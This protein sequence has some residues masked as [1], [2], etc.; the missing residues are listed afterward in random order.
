[1]MDPKADGAGGKKTVVEEG[2][3]FRGAMTSSCPIEVRGRIEGEMSTPSLAISQTGSVHG[4]GK[5]GSLR[6]EGEISG[7]FDADT[8][9]LSGT[10]KDKTVIRAKTLDVRLGA[11]DKRMQ[12]TFGE[13]ELEVGDQPS[14]TEEIHSGD[15]GGKRGRR[16][17]GGDFGDGAGEGADIDE[18]AGG[19]GPSGEM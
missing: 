6:S 16:R 13:C 11:D 1:M 7:E 4:K 14:P 15:R 17:G 10:V 12:V 8:V 2:T 5:I 9:Q 3:D 19:S 18:A